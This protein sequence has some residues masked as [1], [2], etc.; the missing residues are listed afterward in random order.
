MLRSYFKENV[1]WKQMIISIAIPYD[2]STIF[3]HLMRS[4]I[5]QELTQEAIN[6][7]GCLKSPN[8]WMKS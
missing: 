1:I 7:I 6:A 3:R 4:V 2:Y 8:D 5:H